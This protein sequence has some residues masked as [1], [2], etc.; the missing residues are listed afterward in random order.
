MAS[1]ERLA[2]RKKT[3]VLPD[4]HDP[5]AVR[6]YARACLREGSGLR[7]ITERLRALGLPV[8]RKELKRMLL[9]RAA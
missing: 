8:K 1:Q 9:E 4:I 5:A 2:S 7:S 3:P 6:I